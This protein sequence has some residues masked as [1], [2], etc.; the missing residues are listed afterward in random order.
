MITF[1]LN[2]GWYRAAGDEKICRA[3]K[4]RSSHY[5]AAQGARRKR[6]SEQYSPQKHKRELK[7]HKKDKL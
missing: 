6:C 2:C 5:K 4:G 1:L 3:A 7:N